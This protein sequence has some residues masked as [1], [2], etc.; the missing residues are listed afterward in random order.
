M[1]T[2]PQKLP[3]LNDTLVFTLKTEQ[4]VREGIQLLQ[5]HMDHHSEK[6][7][8]FDTETRIKPGCDSNKV[9]VIQL[10]TRELCLVINIRRIVEEGLVFPHSLQL[11]LQEA[12]VMKVGVCAGRDAWALNDSYAIKCAN[13][14]DLKHMAIRLGHRDTTLKSL[15][16]KYGDMKLNKQ[17]QHKRWDKRELR[18]KEVVYAAQD[19]VASYL[20]YLGLKKR[21][22]AQ[23]ILQSDNSDLEKS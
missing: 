9:S 12:N 8:G 23:D 13:V 10:A 14:L 6:V 5:A 4:Q 17:L 11:F 7:V 19:A 16:I 22:E 18:E 21:G 15:A 2:K 1:S 3:G 20:V